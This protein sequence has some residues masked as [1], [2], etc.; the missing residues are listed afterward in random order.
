[1][2]E[3]ETKPVYT[4]ESHPH[5]GD[6]RVDPS[7]RTGR[8]ESSG[9]NME[10]QQTL[11]SLLT[12]PE[13]EEPIQRRKLQKETWYTVQ[14]GISFTLSPIGSEQG[15]EYGGRMTEPTKIRVVGK[16]TVRSGIASIYAFF[17]QEGKEKS[18][19]FALEDVVRSKSK[20]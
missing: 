11:D 9:K 18:G 4:K 14:P 5:A 7:A 3:E 10:N 8:S 12:K 2:S 17:I 13:N 1:M 20:K 16:P 15:A 19:W 6:P